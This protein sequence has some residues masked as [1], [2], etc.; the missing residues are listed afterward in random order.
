MLPRSPPCSAGVPLSNPRSNTHSKQFHEKKIEKHVR[1]CRLAL[2]VESGLRADQRPDFTTAQRPDF[3]PATRGQIFR[4]APFGP[5]AENLA[6]GLGGV[7]QRPDFPTSIYVSDR[8][9]PR[10]RQDGLTW[11]TL[12][13]DVWSFGP[14]SRAKLRKLHTSATGVV[15]VSAKRG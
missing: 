7:G 1:K 2:G 9:G 8:R 15:H 5:Y 12:G 14:R 11:A 6:F 13:A 10:Q 4:I 3:T